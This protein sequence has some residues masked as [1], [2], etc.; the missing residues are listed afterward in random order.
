[1]LSD[2]LKDRYA[3]GES[4]INI[5]SF[6][7]S[8]FVLATVNTASSLTTIYVLTLL[9]PILTGAVH[10]AGFQ[11]AMADMSLEFHHAYTS[12]RRFDEPSLA[13]LLV[14]VNALIC[15]PTAYLF[16]VAATK[17]LTSRPPDSKV[18]AFHIFVI[19]PLFCSCLQAL[20]WKYYDLTPK[21]TAAMREELHRQLS[22]DSSY[23]FGDSP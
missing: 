11:L 18:N 17:I 4:A 5:L 21:R 23:Q 22:T 10:G 19:T 15:K 14:G 8:I 7:I 12:D 1:M 16:A 20:I 13:G 6:L 2:L 9:F 3:L